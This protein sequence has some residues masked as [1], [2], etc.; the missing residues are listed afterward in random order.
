VHTSFPEAW[1][2]KYRYLEIRGKQWGGY[3]AFQLFTFALGSC[4]RVNDMFIVGVLWLACA[5]NGDD[6]DAVR[7]R[8]IVRVKRWPEMACGADESIIFF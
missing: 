5:A 1:L 2:E 3:S 4:L 6:G 8:W 7:G